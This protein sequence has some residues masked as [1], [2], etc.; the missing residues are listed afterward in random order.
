M[1]RAAKPLLRWVNFIGFELLITLFSI[2][3]SPNRQL[4]L[5]REKKSINLK[6]FVFNKRKNETMQIRDKKI[7]IQNV[8]GL[9]KPNKIYAN[10]R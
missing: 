8:F 7:E 2:R 6:K 3:F 1:N 4:S 10:T 5:T 9:G